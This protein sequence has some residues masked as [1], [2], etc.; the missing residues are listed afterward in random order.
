[1]IEFK[2]LIQI[3]DHVYKLLDMIQRTNKKMHD[4]VYAKLQ[5]NSPN[6][7]MVRAVEQIYTFYSKLQLERELV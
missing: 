5:R 3:Q 1:M 2:M 7:T 4:K 6:T